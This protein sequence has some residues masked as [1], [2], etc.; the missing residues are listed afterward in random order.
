MT[1]ELADPDVAERAS[2]ANGCGP[3]EMVSTTAFVA[4]S[5]LQMVPSPSF[6]IHSRPSGPRTPSEGDVPTFVVATIT[7]VVASSRVTERALVGDPHAVVVRIDADF[8][9]AADMDHRNGVGCGID[10]VRVV[11]VLRT[12]PDRTRSGTDARESGC[13][14][15][16]LHLLQRPWIDARDRSC[17]RVRR[18]HGP[19]A[20]SNV[21]RLVADLICLVTRRRRGSTFAIVSCRYSTQTAAAPATT[22][23]IERVVEGSDISPAEYAVTS[24]VAAFANELSALNVHLDGTPTTCSTPSIASRGPF[25]RPWLAAE[26]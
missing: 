14:L 23:H 11:A 8:A 20:V 18:P 1:L 5:I 3:T 26:G 9:A 17:S 2:Y 7:P 21:P 19:K 16:P 24:S 4:G 6:R 10:A 25:A 15:D 12:D 13:G 22:P